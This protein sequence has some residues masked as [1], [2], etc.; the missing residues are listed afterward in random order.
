MDKYVIYLRK[1][2]TDLEAETRGELETLARHEKTLVELAQKMKLPIE[3][4]Y[5]EIVSGETI[6]A[7]PMMQKLLSEV[8]QGFWVGVLVMEIERLARG[9]TVDQGIVANAFKTGNTKIITPLKTYDP[10]NEFDEE[11]FEFGLFMSR[12]EYKT[13][14]RRIQRGRVTSAKEGRF[15]SSVPP[16]GY[17]KVKILNDKGYTLTPN[18]DESKVV[19][20]IF[21]MYNQGKGMTTICNELDRLCIKPKYRE[22]WSKSTIND[23]LDNPVYIGKI[24]WSYKD[25]KKVY[26]DGKIEKHRK[27]NDEY[28]Y[29]DGIHPPIINEET[30]EKAKHIRKIN[31]HTGV[32]KNLVLKNSLSGI[33]YCAKCNSLMTRLGISKKNHYST[34]KCS[35][36]YCDNVSSPIFL[37]ENQIINKTSE[38]Y[39]NLQH[40]INLNTAGK[41]DYQQLSII[42]KSI[43]TI[44]N[45]IT[46]VEKQIS[47]TYVLLEQEVYS[48]EIFTKRNREL[49][50][51]KSKLEN[52]MIELE[53]EKNK[54][55]ETYEI[56]KNYLPQ[57]ISFL[58]SYHDMKSP[59]EK[60]KVLKLVLDKVTYLKKTQNTRGNLNVENFEINIFPKIKL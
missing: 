20:L 60:N 5:K 2:R 36:R 54:Y 26:V 13:I 18:E 4:I 31:T 16:Y 39:N 33:V 24:R 19:Q 15:L 29:V 14:N 38:Y 7:R 30:F 12:R 11:Y 46:T 52:E 1:S 21:D 57:I 41:N 6:A 37:V 47:Q 8:E 17:D 25:E 44:S 45:N 32:N 23:I 51:E 48:I 3:D 50:I 42:E 55:K 9:D 56:K 35:N 10:N 22:T 49:S 34:L 59:T 43:N 53:N 58:K 27:V 40:T 28:I